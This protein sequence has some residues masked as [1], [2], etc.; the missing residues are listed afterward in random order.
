M[1]KGC[2]RRPP[3]VALDTQVPVAYQMPG[4]KKRLMSRID[5]LDG[6]R[7]V[8]ILGVFLAHFTPAYCRVSDLLYLGWTGVDLFFAISG[9]LITTILI[10]LR[11]H[12]T[13]FKTFYWRRTLRILPPYYLALT[14][15]LLLIFLH[16]ENVLH[17]TVV[18]CWLF[19]SSVKL[20]SIK[21]AVSR[22]LFNS[23]EIFPEHHRVTQYY[24]LD[25][26]DCLGA[27]WSLSV[28]E[29]FYLV[30]A[31]LI[32]KGTPRMIVVCS[33]APLLACPILRS[34]AHTPDFDELVG[35]V[36]R[37]DSLAAGGCV[38]LLFCAAAKGYLEQRLLDRGLV[39]TILFSS[40]ALL[41]LASYCGVFRGVDVRSKLIF[42]TFGF[43]LLAILFATVVGAC[44]RW[45][46]S[47]RMVPRFLR[48]KSGVYLGTVSYTMYLIHLPIY[49]LI[50]VTI[51]KYFGNGRVFEANSW[52][53][54][55]WG[56]LAVVCT[57]VVAGVSW[58]YFEA[59]ILRLKDRRFPSLA[60]GQA[61]LSAATATT[62]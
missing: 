26:R 43:T 35:F 30:W 45:S 50:Q 39:L 41:L 40:L 18:R 3:R 21:L 17:G 37:F 60:H 15:I 49:V 32:L 6:L 34:L 36:F 56:I 59:P 10:G 54:A 28:E 4:F 12:E 13:P 22:L 57:I 48:S 29:L 52:L 24:I 25:F 8:A 44:V 33:I 61:S 62:S 53:A 19:L 2:N 5:E 14:L 46:G 11:E 42:S 38:A 1:Q 7:A 31:P 20:G 23:R 58:K 55:L 16:R 51:L 9:F 47:L 27:Y